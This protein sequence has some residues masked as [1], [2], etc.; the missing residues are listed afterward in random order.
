MS[1]HD[2]SNIWLDNVN[3]GSLNYWDIGKEHA[4]GVIEMGISEFGEMERLSAIVKPD[5]CVIT[6]IGQCHLENLG[7]RDGVLKAK[8]EIFTSMKPDGK[9]YLN[10]EDDKL[11]TVTESGDREIL[12]FGG[13]GGDVRAENIVPLGLLGS[14]FTV[15]SGKESFDV[16][17][18]VPG[19]HMVLNA[20]A[21]AAVALDAGMTPGE[22]QAGIEKF[23]PIGGHSSILETEMFTI[24]DDCY[25]ANPVSMKAGLDVL[26]DGLG[27]RVA[28]VGDMFELGE[29]EEKLHREIGSY[30]VNAGT[31]VLLCVGKLSKGT[32][33]IAAETGNGKTAVYY[34]P[35]VEEALEEL[36][37]L[38]QKGDTILVKA[39][40]GMHFEKIV[41]QLKEM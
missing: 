8:T 30:A 11:L 5:A 37:S 25:N 6:N 14:R 29:D 10:G 28:I 38:L 31:D 17:V 35:V 27:R 19:K 36:P 13:E 26:K 9:I 22:I 4:I 1:V 34:F 3:G 15:V 16:T 12:F 24:L 32:Y 7:D 21:A 33:E 23:R 2:G 20:L 18:P 39:S 40:H 41:A